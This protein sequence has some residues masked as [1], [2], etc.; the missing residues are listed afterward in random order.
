MDLQNQRKKSNKSHSPHRKGN[1]THVLLYIPNIIDYIRILF[2]CLFCYVARTDRCAAALCYF[3]SFAL[4]E[5]DGN[6][7]RYLGQT[8][9]FGMLLDILIDEASVTALCHVLATFYPVYTLAFQMFSILDFCGQWSIYHFAARFRN[10][11]YKHQDNWLTKIYFNSYVPNLFWVYGNHVFLL[12]LYLGH[13]DPGPTVPIAGWQVGLWNLLAY[14]SAPWAVS[15]LCIMLVTLF[16][17]MYRLALMQ[18]RSSSQGGDDVNG[19][20]TRMTNGMNGAHIQRL[21]A[22][23]D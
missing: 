16:D 11:D 13:G 15:R 14:L 21:H 20:L 4:D 5:L 9:E 3:V 8:S 22:N 12:A 18:H 23:D 10:N 19:H 17:R 7:A 2:L 6:L 1:T